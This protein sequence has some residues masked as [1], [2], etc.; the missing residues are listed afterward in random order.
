MVEPVGLGYGDL[1]GFA[2]GAHR[3]WRK[4]NLSRYVSGCLSR[5]L[6]RGRWAAFIAKIRTA[7]GAG[8]VWAVEAHPRSRSDIR[9]SGVL[10]ISMW[11]TALFRDELSSRVR[12]VQSHR[13]FACYGR[14]PRA[15]QENDLVFAD[16]ILGEDRMNDRR[17]CRVGG[18]RGAEGNHKGT[19]GWSQP[20][21]TLPRRGT[22][23]RTHTLRQ[24]DSHR[25]VPSVPE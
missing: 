21:L 7:S 22:G 12:F 16:E 4:R 20:T 8:R 3:R 19:C 15:T 1:R 6:A 5:F 14:L 11:S 18:D 25:K 10:G 13:L 17:F 2:G 24:Q 23:R 9:R